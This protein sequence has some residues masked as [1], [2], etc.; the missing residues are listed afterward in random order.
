MMLQRSRAKVPQH[1]QETFLF[2]FDSNV[3]DE[4]MICPA[5]PKFTMLLLPPLQQL[6][7][8]VGSQRINYRMQLL[9]KATI[10]NDTRCSANTG[11]VSP[12]HL[13]YG[14]PPRLA[15]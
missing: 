6:M 1:E 3:N 9:A 2:L 11:T 7:L 5:V 4:V 14:I 10:S 15:L 12:I 8:G 13:G